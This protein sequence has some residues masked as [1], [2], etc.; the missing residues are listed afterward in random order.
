MYRTSNYSSGKSRECDSNLST[1]SRQVGLAVQMHHHFRSRF[2]IDTLF[3]TG[4]CSS[5]CA[6]LRFEE[7]AASSVA[8]DV[9]GCSDLSHM[10]VLFARDNVD[11]NIVSLD[12]KAWV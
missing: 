4:Y 9:L 6:V 11:R 7:N 8:S 2:L 10:M 5:Y 3:A 12:G 1:Y